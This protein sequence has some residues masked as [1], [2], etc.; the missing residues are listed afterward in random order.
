MVTVLNRDVFFA[1]RHTSL[2]L[3]ERSRENG[4]QP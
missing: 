1:L 2:E 4:P 3:A